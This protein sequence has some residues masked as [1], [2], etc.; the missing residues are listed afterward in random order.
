MDTSHPSPILS[1]HILTML[2]TTLDVDAT[3]KFLYI[4]FSLWECVTFEPLLC[5]LNVHYVNDRSDI[6]SSTVIFLFRF[7][8][9]KLKSRKRINKYIC[10]RRGKDT[11]N[12]TFT[13]IA[14]V[15]IWLIPYK[16]HFQTVILLS[17]YSTRSPTKLIFDNI[18]LT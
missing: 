1:V 3:E 5:L 18:L 4:K 10:L 13:F 9:T 7:S 14:Y 8:F 6:L 15:K 16:T 2:L 12:S 17:S 11:T